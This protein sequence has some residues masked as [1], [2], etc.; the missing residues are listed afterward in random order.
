METGLN[1]SHMACP[2]FELLEGNQAFNIDGDDTWGG[3]VY[4]TYFRNHATGKRRSYP[5]TCGR[6]A[7]GLM[8]GHYFYSFVGNVLGYRGHERRPLLRLRLRRSLPLG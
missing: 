5:D 2:H 6:R 3:A 1:A 7:I 8:M 4:N